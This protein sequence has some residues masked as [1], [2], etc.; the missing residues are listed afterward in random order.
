MARASAAAR[1]KDNKS[2]VPEWLV[3]FAD[4]MSILVCFFVLIISFSIQDERKLQ[5]VAGSMR[6]AFGFSQTIAR[7]GV[8]EREG[9]P[10]RDFLKLVTQEPDQSDSQFET[11]DH[12]E[13]AQQGPEAQ[14]FELERAELETPR[15]FSLAAASI[16]QAW[17]ENPV[18][19]DI[20]DNLI[21][22]ETEEGLNILIADQE[23]RPMFAEGSR[24][25][26]EH[27][28]QALATIA[29]ALQRLPNQIRISGHT[30]AGI[31]YVDPE[32]GAWELSFD[33]ANV[34]RQILEEFG[35]SASRIKAVV[36]RAET[37][38]YFANDPYLA[39]NQRIKITVLNEEPPVPAQWAP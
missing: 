32:Y 36:G 26:F 2:E 25:P 19:T 15:R 12:D 1:K 4:L 38:P 20:T 39:A 23:G 31:S 27:T 37:D 3:T 9:T 22:E 11:Q 33:R 35:L 6:D 5:I 18:I 14:T 29:P 24:Y 7:A 8:I 17:R 10:Q 21:L 34:S 28:R 16:E 30:A 13:A